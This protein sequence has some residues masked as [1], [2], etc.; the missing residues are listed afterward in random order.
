[1]PCCTYLAAKKTFAETRETA[2][3]RH[4]GWVFVYVS[5]YL[6]FFFV[7]LKQIIELELETVGNAQRISREDVI[8]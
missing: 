5:N 4:F 6:V 1:M 8:T 2:L 7:K 3:P